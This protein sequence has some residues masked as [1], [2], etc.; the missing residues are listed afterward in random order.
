MNRSHARNAGGSSSDVLVE[1]LEG[2]RL[3]S[4]SA[5]PGHILFHNNGHLHTVA[6]ETLSQ[7]ALLTA[8]V[9]KRSEQLAGLAATVD[10]GDGAT[11]DTSAGFQTVHG[12][13]RLVGGHTYS[14]AGV[15]SVVITVSRE[16][17]TIAS[18]KDAV[19]VAPRTPNGRALSAGAMQSFNAVLG[20][21]QNGPWSAAALTIDWGDGSISAPTVSSHGGRSVLSG[22]HTYAGAGHYAVVVTRAGDGTGQAA[23]PYLLVADVV[24]NA[25]APVPPAKIIT[26]NSPGGLNLVA[27]AGTPF[28]GIIGTLTSSLTPV[29]VAIEWGDGTHSPGTFVSLGDDHYQISGGHT[30]AAPGTYTANVL[31]R[32]GNRPLFPLPGQALPDSVDPVPQVYVPV[33]S[34]ITVTGEPTPPPA[35]N[36]IITAL[37]PPTA[38]GDFLNAPL[39][40]LQNVSTAPDAPVP[41]AVVDYGLGTAGSFET[42]VD[43]VGNG[44]FVLNATNDFSWQNPANALRTTFAGILHATITFKLSDHVNQADDTILGSVSQTINAVPNSQG[45]VTLNLAAGQTYSGSIGVV[46]FTGAQGGPLLGGTVDWGDNSAGDSAVTLTPLG[47]DRYQ[48]NDSHAYAQPGRYRISLAATYKDVNGYTTTDYGSNWLVSTAVVTG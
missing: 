26:G 42:S 37:P 20:S 24:V 44:Q 7:A 43:P 47:G 21:V 41:Y 35:S 30:Y 3:L 9:G 15:Y 4:A 14:Q 40:T 2:R 48:I 33:V 36:A 23:N 12:K 22:F 5:G 6:G 29:E 10:W 11:A 28:T 27:I 16:G 17:S 39:A 32:F 19:R 18:V 1:P 34:T 13:L 38:Y 25:A 8:H 31:T 46:T 45:G